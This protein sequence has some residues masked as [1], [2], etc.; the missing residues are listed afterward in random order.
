MTSASAEAA[1][2]M[3][4]SRELQKMPSGAGTRDP[5]QRRTR[6]LVPANFA[7]EGQPDLTA[8]APRGAATG[9]GSVPVHQRL[10]T[11]S[12]PERAGAGEVGWGRV[13]QWSRRRPKSGQ[14][15]DRWAKLFSLI[16]LRS[17]KSPCCR[18]TRSNTASM[19]LSERST[20]RISSAGSVSKL[21]F[22]S[23]SP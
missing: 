5:R 11:D 7:V 6:L 9:R 16:W 20:R 8:V 2:E 17:N 10:P 12:S 18:R 1:C 22:Q 3:R 23:W 15:C 21:M 13:L 4:A 14:S 19:S